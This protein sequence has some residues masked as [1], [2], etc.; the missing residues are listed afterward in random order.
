MSAKSSLL[1]DTLIG[2]LIGGIF[3]LMMIV[4]TALGSNFNPSILLFGGFLFTIS[5]S[6]FAFVKDGGARKGI[7]VGLLAGFFTP[8]I[9]ILGFV[10]ITITIFP[11]NIT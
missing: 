2:L 8:L 3:P 1:I 4:L 5:G 9:L 10:F 6:V 11:E 7:G